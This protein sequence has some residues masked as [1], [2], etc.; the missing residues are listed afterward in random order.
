MS[1]ISKPYTFSAG[2]TIVA[3][4]HNANFDTVYNLVNG[5]IDNA[6]IKSGAGI[7]DSKLAQISSGSKVLG[8]ALATLSGVGSSAG[9]I[10][11]ANIPVGTASGNVVQ[12]VGTSLLPALNASSCTSIN[13]NQLYAGTI[14]TA[15]LKSYDSGWFAVAKASVYSGT[16]N[17]LTTAFLSTVYVS[18]DNAGAIGCIGGGALNVQQS[19]LVQCNLASVDTALWYLRT[20]TTYIAYF[21][22]KDG[23]EI[24]AEKGYARVVML[25]P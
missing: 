19:S 12:L 24:A 10:P 16:H 9:I 18:T 13:A 21:Q 1:V 2:S 22:D 15:R 20:G 11:V 6:N 14:P 8:T 3:S 7:E 23:N 17:L 25:A 4:E 5:N